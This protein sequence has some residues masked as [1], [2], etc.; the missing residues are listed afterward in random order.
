M[1]RKCIS[2]LLFVGLLLSMLP[3]ASASDTR[4]VTLTSDVAFFNALSLSKMPKVQSA[5]NAGNY[6]LAKQELL[7]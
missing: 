2:V 7:N 3:Y 1:F 6:T 5:V 4:G